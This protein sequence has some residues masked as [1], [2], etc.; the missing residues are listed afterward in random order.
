MSGH[1]KWSNIQHRK[2]AQDAKRGKIFQKLSKEIYK[3]AKDGGG[4]PETNAALRLAVDKAK[5]NNMPNDNVDRAIK[6]ATDA[7]QGDNFVEVMYEGYGPNGIAVLVEGLTDNLNRTSTNVKVAFNKNG[8]SL[9]E[10]GSVNYMFDRKGY[11][12]IDREGLDVDED[13]M[14]MSVLEAG[15]E[16]LETSDEVFE[17]YTEPQDFTDVRDAL[18]A[19]GYTLDQAELTMVPQTTVAVPED[20]I[21]TFENMI[22]ALEDDDDVSEVYHNAEI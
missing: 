15:G 2:G 22:D 10:K 1:S 9:G 8:G 12:A 21:Q 14:L 5:S 3:A 13:T 7:G 4:D 20:K 17:I 19:V 16:E 11:I 18:T 6:R